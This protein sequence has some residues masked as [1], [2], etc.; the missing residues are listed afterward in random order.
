MKKLFRN[1]SEA[2]KEA[3]HSSD[4]SLEQHVQPACM[5]PVHLTENCF[6]AFILVDS[7]GELP[8]HLKI[9]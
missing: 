7:E 3:P 9:G 5:D 4:L 2:R 8:L 1:V 6:L